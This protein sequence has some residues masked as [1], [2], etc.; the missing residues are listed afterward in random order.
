ADYETLVHV[1]DQLDRLP[2]AIELAAAR[3][4]TVSVDELLARLEQR[5]PLLTSRRRDVDERE[6]TLRATIGG[7]YDLL[8]E[9][10]RE[11]FAA[12]SVFVGSFDAAAADAVCLADLDGLESLVDKSLLH[13]RSDGR[14]YM[15][16]TIREY[17]GAVLDTSTA[18]H[19]LHRRH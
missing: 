11:L 6:R 19:E 16:E 5:L 13:R 2:L 9:D 10:D 17:A 15:L 12:L 4:K 7:G 18:A 1:C 8:A 3:T 14:F